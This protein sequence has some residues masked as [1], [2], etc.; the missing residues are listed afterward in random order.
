MDKFIG[1]EF[2]AFNALPQA[3][4]WLNKYAERGYTLVH[5]NCAYVAQGAAVMPK[6]LVL[7]QAPE[8]EQK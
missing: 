1:Q 7:M 5:V 4:E 6:V 3:I 8:Q 2:S